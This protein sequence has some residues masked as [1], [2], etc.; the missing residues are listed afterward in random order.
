MFSYRTEFPFI[1]NTIT[2]KLRKIKYSMSTEN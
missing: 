1:N 2:H